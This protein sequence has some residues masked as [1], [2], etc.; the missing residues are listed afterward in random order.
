MWDKDFW[1]LSYDS[2]EFLVF[3]DKILRRWVKGVS[4]NEEAKEKYTVPFKN[5]C[6]TVIG[7]FNVK[8]VA[9]GHRRAA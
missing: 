8:M 1:F 3:R 6:S 5:R 9:D 7:S 2:L 4:T